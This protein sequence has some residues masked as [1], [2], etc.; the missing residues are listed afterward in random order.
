MNAGLD[1]VVCDGCGRSFTTSDGAAMLAAIKGACP[2]CGGRFV[3]KRDPHTD[4]RREP[5]RQL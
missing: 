5:V 2:D 3:L 1:V 4:E